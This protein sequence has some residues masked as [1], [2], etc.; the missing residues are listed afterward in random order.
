MNT[1][2]RLPR[3]YV[4]GLAVL[5]LLVSGGWWLGRPQPA[6]QVSGQIVAAAAAASAGFARVNTP[7]PIEFPRD[8]GPH[9]AY[10]T[11]W[12]Y[13]VGN[14]VSADGRRFGFQLT[15]F[16]RALTPEATARTSD[17]AANQ[18]YMAHFALSDIGAQQFHAFDRYSRGAA[19]LA[20]AQAEPYRVWLENWSVEGVGPRTERLRAQQDGIALDLTLTWG[21]APALHGEAGLHQKG[22]ETGNASMYYSLTR[23]PLQGA[24]TLNGQTFAVT[25]SGWMDHEFG[26]TA[27]GA[28]AI[29]W[30][31]FALQL[32]DGR[33]LMVY[34]IR[35]EDGTIEPQSSG[36]LIE[37]DGRVQHLDGRDVQITV[38]D[39]WQSAASGG[40]YPARWRVDLPAFALTLTITPRQADQELRLAQTYWEGAVAIEG[41][42]GGQPISGQGYVELTG[43]VG[44]LRGQF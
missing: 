35:R 6:A 16:R 39:T 43:Y 41:E 4:V 19:G 38:L 23:L 32:D 3:R 33:E 7:L 25:G 9:P 27:L 26:T 30:D 2:Q 24:V 18:A 37:A 12:W 28:R 1:K 8:H 5:V 13:Y 10:L 34:Q 29:G 40:R 31:W 14:L 11:E 44:T 21:K 20:G 36:S 22:P 42:T 15:F 17:W